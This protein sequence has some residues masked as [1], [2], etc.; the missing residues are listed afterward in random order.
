ME[1]GRL[2][3]RHPDG[4][5]MCPGPDD[6]K[7]LDPGQPIPDSPEDLPGALPRT[8]TVG[9]LLP[10][11]E[12]HRQVATEPA[13]AEIPGVHQAS[14]QGVEQYWATPLHFPA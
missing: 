4:G 12:A 6:S 13:P 11:A 7:S 3:H 2:D 9:P 14:L 5:G 1:G 8:D 10:G